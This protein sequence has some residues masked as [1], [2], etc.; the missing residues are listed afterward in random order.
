MTEE[1]RKQRTRERWRQWRA[2]NP[3]RARLY[4][5]RW[6]TSPGRKAA[7]QRY[8]AKRLRYP[9]ERTEEQ[10]LKANKRQSERYRKMIT[11]ETGE[12]KRLRLARN[13]ERF[14][15]QFLSRESIFLWAIKSYLRNRAAFPIALASDQYRHLQ[16][17]RLRT[18]RAARTWLEN[19]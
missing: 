9:K 13:R 12:E 15:D 17:V 2:A 14:V 3:E 4:A 19:L 8:Q 1:E 7:A 11:S 16:L 10:R 18:P 6:N 5:K